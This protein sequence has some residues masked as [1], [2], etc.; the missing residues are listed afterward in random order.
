MRHRWFVFASVVFLI[1]GMFIAGSRR[2]DALGVFHARAAHTMEQHLAQPDPPPTQYDL[3]IAQIAPVEGV[4]IPVVWGAMGQRLINVGA[5]D[6]QLFTQ[7]NGGQDDEELQILQGD[8]LQTITFTPENIRLWT[9]I[10]WALG[11]TQQS[12]VLSEGPMQQNSDQMPLDGYASTGGWTLG[13]VD[14]VTL[15]NSTQLVELTPEQDNMVYHVASGI[16]RPCCGNSTAFPDCN[17]GMAVLGLLELLASRG[18]AEDELYAAALTF[19]HYA[20]P[21]TY[22]TAAVFM[23]QHEVLTG[24]LP[25]EVVLSRRFSSG[26]AAQWMTATV[27]YIPGSPNAAG[28]C[29][30]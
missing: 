16:Y 8:S 4:T 19:N 24:S 20:F 14:A 15:Y 6:L 30:T 1:L 10:L 9:N 17:H 28:N 18:A 27:G 12:K 11:L 29:G 26:Q 21:D 25:P 7:V 13:N 22:I 2:G 23:D 3:L 5:I